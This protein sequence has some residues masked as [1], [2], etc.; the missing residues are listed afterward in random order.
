MK[1]TTLMIAT[2]LVLAITYLPSSYSQTNK[3]T[4]MRVPATASVTGTVKVSI[5]FEFS[6]A[7]KTFEAGTYYIGP[8][9]EG[10]EM[11]IKSVS[12]KSAVM[13]PTN[14]VSA[15][16][17]VVPPKLVF[18]KYGDQYFLAQTWLKYS[19]EG[20]EFFAT[21]EELKM[22]REHSQKTVVLALVRNMGIS[23]VPAWS[24]RIPPAAQV[25]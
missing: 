7:G 5:P 18:H 19:D 11:A 25:R 9:N 1:R 21:P 8:A 14:L 4:E 24:S 2:V 15:A 13:A 16:N 12:G 17:K 3:T 23:A 22:A 10:N 20:R 6:V